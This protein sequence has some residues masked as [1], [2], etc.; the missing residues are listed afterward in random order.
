MHEIEV[1][2]EIV[3]RVLA[4]RGRYHIFDTLDPAETAF[5]VIDMQGTFVAGLARRGP[6]VA[7]HRCKHQCAG[8]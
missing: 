8:G 1:R 6:G 2:Q 3:D 4:R 7:R 5:V